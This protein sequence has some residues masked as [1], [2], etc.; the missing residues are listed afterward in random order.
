M[1][2]ARMD[3]LSAVAHRR[4]QTIDITPDRSDHSRRR[5]G[6]GCEAGRAPQWGASRPALSLDAMTRRVLLV[7]DHDDTRALMATLLR[8]EGHEVFARA[9][10]ED[11]IAHIEECDAEVAILDLRLP[12]E[13]GDEFGRRLKER[14]PET[15]VIFVTAESE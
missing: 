4:R 11:A 14:C 9:S 1:E 12:G 3:L 15:K 6:V 8:R 2:R 5:A 10:S 13:Y 7:E